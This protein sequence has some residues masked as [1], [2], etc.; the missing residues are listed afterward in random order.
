MH[1][2]VQYRH[3]FAGIYMNI[4]KINNNEVYFI[5]LRKE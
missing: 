4:D 1:N 2:M 5:Y 3:N